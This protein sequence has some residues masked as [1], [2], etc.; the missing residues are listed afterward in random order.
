MKHLKKYS[1]FLKETFIPYTYSN[2]LEDDEY[3]V[4]PYP[5]SEVK[6]VVRRGAISDAIP[7]AYPMFFTEDV[8]TAESYGNHVKE[9]YINITN[10][11]DLYSAG[12]GR[13]GE[14]LANKLL[15]FV[16]STAEIEFIKNN[17]LMNPRFTIDYMSYK[18]YD[19][20]FEKYYYENRRNRKVTR[21][22]LQNEIALAYFKKISDKYED[23]AYS[24]LNGQL[25]M[26]KNAIGHSLTTVM[27]LTGVDNMQKVFAY[28]KE[29]NY[30]GIMM[31]DESRDCQQ[32][33]ISY[34]VFKPSQ[35]TWLRD[36]THTNY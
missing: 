33:C 9:A 27:N 20:D 14:G 17:D 6:N 23:W 2:T 32:K 28:A 30:D 31:H 3:P 1:T 12:E 35:I 8:Y 11:L 36:Y 7:V 26:I 22:E 34:V 10:M 18:L 4:S 15:P 25:F 24:I 5:T 21:S 29:H 13:Y 16:Y 19:L